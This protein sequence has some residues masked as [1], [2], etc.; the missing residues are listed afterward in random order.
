V[1]IERVRRALTTQRI[2]ADLVYLPTTTSTMDIVR[3]RAAAGAAEG[4]TVLADEQT[5][6]RGRLSR[7]WVAPPGVN[8]YVSILV[9]PARAVM[10]RLGIITPL[11]VAEAVAA[12]G[13][14]AVEFKWPNDIRIAGLKLCGVLIEGGFSGDRPD[15]AVVGIG[16][17]VN[18]DV[19]A[20]PEISDIAT[21]LRRELGRDVS[22]EDTLAALLNAFERLYDSTDGAALRARWRARLETLGQ[23]VDV[24]FGGHTEHGVAEDVDEEG[25]LIL[26]R[27][28]GSQVTLPAG[29]VTLRRGG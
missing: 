20:H 14:P 28:D 7:V 29:E 9:R 10:K 12:V 26:R 4:L 22:R 25:A 17:N 24:T 2:G 13:G 3:E 23:E 1:D 18:L 19:K 15:F 16:L 27:P 11:A 6:G 8:L 5:A 21:S